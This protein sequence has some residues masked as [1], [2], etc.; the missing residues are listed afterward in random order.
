MERSWT[1]RPPGE[2]RHLLNTLAPMLE[3]LF[4]I[5]IEAGTGNVVLAFGEE[6][7]AEVRAFVAGLTRFTTCVGK[8]RSPETD[9]PRHQTEFPNGS[10]DHNR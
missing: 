7:E 1:L 10:N 6:R 5:T 8:G 3:G 9:L 4:S 2:V